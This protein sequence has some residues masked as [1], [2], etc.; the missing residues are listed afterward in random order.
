LVILEFST[1]RHNPL[2]ALYSLYFRHLLP[3]IGRIVSKHRDAYDWLPAS[4]AAFASPDALAAQL[5][6]A[7]FVGVR[8]ETLAGGICAIHVGT[9]E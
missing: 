3:R 4:V 2:R 1:P 7:G 5:G 6:A 8:W 9:R